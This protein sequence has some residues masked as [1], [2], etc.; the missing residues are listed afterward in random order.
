VIE[1]EGAAAGAPTLKLSKPQYG[2]L[3]SP[4]VQLP[5]RAGS[6]RLIPK[7]GAGYGFLSTKDVVEVSLV[8]LGTAPIENT[9]LVNMS[10]VFAVG[11]IE[12]RP[13]PYIAISGDY[14][15]SVTAS[16]QFSE[17]GRTDGQELEDPSFSRLRAGVTYRVIPS[18][19]LGGEFI[20]RKLSFSPD[21]FEVITNQFL[22]LVM[23]Q[24]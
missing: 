16:G 7:L 5:F 17:T 6:V 12:F 20:Q 4:K 1:T 23:Y 15:R 14:A 24:L 3:F 9:T 19:H 11:G 21:Q 13:V 18:L 2:V 22:A 8:G 10:G